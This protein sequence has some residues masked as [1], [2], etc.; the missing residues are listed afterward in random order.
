MSAQSA[1]QKPNIRQVASLAGVSHMTVSRV[2]NDFPNIRPE[3]RQRVL[4]VIS[5]LGYRPN[6]AARALATQRSRRFGVIVE[7]SLEYGPISTL[8]GVEAAARDADYTVTSA[9]LRD[10]EAVTP[11]D[12]VDDLISQGV[13]AICMITPRSASVAALRKISIGVPVLVV[14]SDNDP[15][16][17]T[18]AVDQVHGT[19]LLVDHLAALGHRDILHLSG[20]LDWLDARV[21]ER[22][23]HARSSSW[24][25]R[26]RPI[27]V[28]DWTA[29]FAYDYVKGLKRR[30]DYTAI[31][32]AN[33]EMALGLLHGFHDRG[34]GVPDE[35]SVVGFD[36]VPLSP[37]FIPP[38]TTVR[39]DFLALGAKV[40][41]VL[42]AA[43][44]G[45]EIPQ[46]SRLPVE[47]KV[48]SSSGPVRGGTA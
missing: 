45:G 8:R 41:E 40:V 11:Q 27:V 25:M 5:E 33:D 38:L 4:D 35:L 21:R 44:E 28:G 23:F 46:Q 36:D 30:P 26:Q 32:A 16:F 13:D 34:L 14:K 12:I 31:F 48:R 17:L 18:V 7:S 29:D 37:H 24:G 19:E 20:P 15:N 2:L 1:A 10:D 43:A 22:T 6:S 42:R 9:A 39:Q 47:L 3:T